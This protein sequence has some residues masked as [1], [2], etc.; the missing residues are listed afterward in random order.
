M[1]KIKNEMSHKEIKVFNVFLWK[2]IEYIIT[3]SIIINC[4]STKYLTCNFL[5]RKTSKP[6]ALS[7]TK[8]TFIAQ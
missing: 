2:K 1:M 3:S 8:A 5:D 6:S 4:C 7:D